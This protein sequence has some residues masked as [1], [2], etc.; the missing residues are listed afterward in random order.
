M[1]GEWVK[2][3]YSLVR[4]HEVPG[5]TVI[6]GVCVLLQVFIPQ[7]SLVGHKLDWSEAGEYVPYT[8]DLDQGQAI[9]VDS[10]IEQKLSSM[11]RRT[12]HAVIL[13]ALMKTH[14]SCK[15]KL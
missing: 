13:R 9:C 10:Y 5:G 7:I 15:K 4:E 12:M 11:G 1:V 8:A 14:C 6:G 3:K 2:A